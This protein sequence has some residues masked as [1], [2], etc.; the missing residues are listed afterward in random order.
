MRTTVTGVSGGHPRDR[1][2][3]SRRLNRPRRAVPRRAPVAESTSRRMNRRSWPGLETGG[4]GTASEPAPGRCVAGLVPAVRA[5]WLWWWRGGWECPGGHELRHRRG[6]RTPGQRPAAVDRVLP[7]GTGSGFGRRQSPTGT[8]AC[9]GILGIAGILRHGGHLAASRACPC[10]AC[11]AWSCGRRPARRLHSG[12]TAAARRRHCSSC[13]APRAR[14]SPGLFTRIVMY[15]FARAGAT[16]VC[17]RSRPRRSGPGSSWPAQGPRA[18]SPPAPPR[19][20]ARFLGLP[21]AWPVRRARQR[22][23]SSRHSAPARPAEA[24]PARRRRRRRG[25]ARVGERHD[26]R[27]EDD[28]QEGHAISRPEGCEHRLRSCTPGH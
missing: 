28:E 17:G 27:R 10:W 4:A 1:S 9:T 3:T 20:R 8:S 25:P 19:P 7:G 15:V 16:A 21:S 14:R 18:A 24:P 26:R 13:P 2:R 5:C 23:R 11:P 12:A 22:P 6:R